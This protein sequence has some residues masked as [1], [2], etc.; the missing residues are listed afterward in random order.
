MM[1][2]PPKGHPIRLI[3]GALILAAVGFSV[4]RNCTNYDHAHLAPNLLLASQLRNWVRHASW[5]GPLYFPFT[6]ATCP[7][8]RAA[9]ADRIRGRVGSG[10][11]EGSRL[12][13]QS[14]FPANRLA[15]H[16]MTLQIAIAIA[17]DHASTHISGPD[18]L[19]DQCYNIDA[20]VEGDK[21]LS[22]EDM[23]PLLQNLLQERFHLVLHHETKT[24]SGYALVVA[25]NSP[26]LHPSKEDAEPHIYT[27]PDG[28][29]IR[30]AGVASLAFALTSQG[31]AGGPIID[32]TGI[33]G[34]YDI[35]LH[36]ATVRSP[37]ANLPDL[38]TAL[39]EQL[40]LKLVPEK[41]PV[42]FLLIDHVD[43]TPTEN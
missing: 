29:D 23:Q 11:P 22:R 10:M 5:N 9:N 33:Q 25:K 41:V 17:F 6:I 4:K 19:N 8:T 37:N 7:R 12:P 30:H 36:Y 24:L 21:Q 13:S 28:I 34:E 27:L 18:W 14:S 31:A 20:K 3:R 43:K 42:D 1:Y 32:K 26:R 35:T 15:F 39:Q 40:G 38:V 2:A 16:S